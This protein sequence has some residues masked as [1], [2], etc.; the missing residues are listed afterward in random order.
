MGRELIPSRP[1]YS[2]YWYTNNFMRNYTES[3][4]T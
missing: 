1:V 3:Q 2:I 4:A